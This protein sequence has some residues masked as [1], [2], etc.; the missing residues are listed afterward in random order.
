[1][2]HNPTSSHKPDYSQSG[3]FEFLLSYF[4]RKRGGFY[5]DCGALDGIRH[6]NTFNLESEFGWRGLLVEVSATYYKKLIQNR[7][8]VNIF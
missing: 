3:Q 1:M 7:S 8:S 6:S 4:H 5:V 2:A